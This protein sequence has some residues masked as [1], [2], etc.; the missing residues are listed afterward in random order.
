MALTPDDLL[1]KRFNEVGF[2]DA[3]YDQ[4]EVDDYLDEVAEAWRQDRAE[5]EQLRAEVQ[6]LR[7]GQPAGVVTAAPAG[8][9]E[10]YRPTAESSTS[11]LAMAQKLHDEHVAEGEQRRA[12]L[13]AE[14]EAA[15]D[16]LVSKA[17]ADAQQIENDAQAR[18]R[19]LAE[20]FETTK[21]S[22]AG[23][24]QQLENKIDELQ[25]FERDYRLRLRGYIE[26]Q[27][28]EL[29]RTSSLGN[30]ADDEL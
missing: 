25:S 5:L 13:I 19:E 27:L 28:R 15:R 24:Q 8:E 16:E 7:A 6:Q 20:S 26:M 4:E 9:G 3:Y 12:E 18:S 14:G 22:F 11:L 10:E 1:H 2:N 17:Q 30:V 29:D 21:Q 23:Q